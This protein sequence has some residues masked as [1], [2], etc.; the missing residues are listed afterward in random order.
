MK[1]Y[2]LMF[3]SV[4]IIV[5]LVGNSYFQPALTDFFNTASTQAVTERA[6]IESA[7]PVL[8]QINYNLTLLREYS[9]TLFS[10]RF[11]RYVA[12]FNRDGNTTTNHAATGQTSV[13][14]NNTWRLVGLG[15]T[16]GV[17]GLIVLLTFGAIIFKK[18]KVSLAAALL[19]FFAMFLTWISFGLHFS[20]SVVTADFCYG[21]Q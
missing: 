2:H 21:I 17:V 5:G 10:L 3:A 1:S 7:Q 11:L 8:L 19:G 9:I 13:G 18:P 4:M 15:F 14:D 6:R 12:T 16:Y 20:F